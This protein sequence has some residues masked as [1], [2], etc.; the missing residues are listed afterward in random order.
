MLRSVTALSLQ[1]A[2]GILDLMLRGLRDRT[3][4]QSWRPPVIPVHIHCMLQTR[5]SIKIGNKN[6]GM[7]Y[8]L[9]QVVAGVVSPRAVRLPDRDGCVRRSARGKTKP[10]STGRSA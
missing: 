5:H 1:I 6:R 7:G 3:E 2:E 8:A 10:A 4:W 9:L